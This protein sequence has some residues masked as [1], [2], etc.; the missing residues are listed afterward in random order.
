MYKTYLVLGIFIAGA[1]V[2]LGAFGAHGL[3]KLVGVETVAIYQ[4][5]VQYQMYH[6]IALLIVGILYER[7]PNN[8]LIYAGIFFL[9]GIVFFSGSLYAMAVLRAMHKSVFPLIGPMTPIGGLF[10]ITGWMLLFFGILRK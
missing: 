2:V 1:S 4:T 10:L 5:G 3:K 7:W 6:A 8:L 9:A